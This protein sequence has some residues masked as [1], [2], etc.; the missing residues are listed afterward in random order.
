M[1]KHLKAALCLMVVL[2]MGAGLL[3]GCQ[4][5]A[6]TGAQSAAPTAA[7][8]DASAQPSAGPEADGPLSPMKDLVELS[9]V[10]GYNAP[11]DATTPSGTTP[12]TQ[13]FNKI[14]EQ[15]LN[16][17]LNYLWTVPADQ[18]DQKFKLAIS[19]G[20]IPDVMKISAKD[21]VDFAE[22]GSLADMR[23]AYDKYCIQDLKSVYEYFKNAPLDQCTVDGK[24]LSIPYCWDTT[25]QV[26]LL[27]IRQDWLDKLK[28]Q[29][30]KTIDDVLAIAV[31]FATQDPDGNGQA[32]T[33]GLGL[34]KDVYAWS[35]DARGLFHGYG[36]YPNAWIKK[37][38]KLVPGTIQ[39][40]VKQAL[41]KLRE[42]YEKGGINKEFAVKT[43]DQLVEDTVASKVGMFYGEWWVP[44]WPLNNNLQKDP[45]ADWRAFNI[46]SPD[47]SPAVTIID[48]N[49]IA[50]YNVVSAKASKDAAAAAMKVINL[51]WDISFN[52]EAAAIYGEDIKPA[53]GYVYNWVPIYSYLANEQMINFQLVNEALEK[54]DS[55]ALYTKT[56]T[57]LFQYSNDWKGKGVND[58][59]GWKAWGMWYSRVAKDGGWG[60]TV[61]AKEAGSFLYNEYY[62][63]PTPT[64][65]EKGATLSDMT[66]EYFNKFIMGSVEEGSWDKFVSDWKALGG[67]TWTQEVNEQYAAMAK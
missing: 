31:A 9:C 41:I 27:Y 35:L 53:S 2:A 60:L 66:K 64:E 49:N 56:Q 50:N 42:F 16:I 8:A 11:E 23:E 25:Q 29:A 4:T 5:A 44:N 15:K 12:E 52:K 13:M 10:V 28:L 43:T 40:E 14:L 54:N 61:K 58:E 37:D 48:R 30:P 62:G 57:E 21:F 51:Q 32:D 65:L 3:A 33:T 39:P 63:N 6:P 46:V 1:K 7:P 20:D 26:N 22:A 17:R 47:G 55:S 24:L 19:S 59:N 38:D 67:D 34:Y 18:Y 36:A 45:K